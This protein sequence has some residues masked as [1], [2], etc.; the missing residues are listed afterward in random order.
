QILNRLNLDVMIFDYRGYGMSTGSPSENG[1]YLDAEAVFNY[2]VNEKAILPWEIIVYGESLGAAIAVDLAGKH[3]LGGIIIE[4]GFT[5]VSDMTKKILPFIPAVIYASRYDALE[6]IK[7]IKSPKLIFHSVDDEIIPFEMGEKLFNEAAEP[8]EFV[9]IQGGHND[10]F[11]TS[12][13]VYSEKIDS[14]ISGL[15]K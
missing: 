6:K 15:L 2:L 1:L 10:A 11:L 12:H 3:D 7:N 14:F 8:K 13:E 9:K 4:G 5:S